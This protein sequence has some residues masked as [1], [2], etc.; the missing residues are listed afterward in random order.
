MPIHPS[1][2]L[3][4]LLLSACFLQLPKPSNPE[5]D[6]LEELLPQQLLPRRR[7]Q[8]LLLCTSTD[9]AQDFSKLYTI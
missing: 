5:L 3:G 7:L 9:S 2:S 1:F 8:V 4:E 6:L